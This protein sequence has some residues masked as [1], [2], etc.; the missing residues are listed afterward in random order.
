[1]EEHVNKGFGMLFASRA[2][3]ESFL[4]DQCHPAPLGNIS[5]A[6]PDG[7]VKHR[8]IQDL[9]W[10]KVNR[11]SRVPERGVLPRPLDHGS[12][13]AKVAAQAGEGDVM[14]TLILDFENAFM[15][16]PLAVGEHRY[17]CCEVPQGLRRSRTQ[18]YDSEPEAGQ[19]V[20]WRVL[21]FGG[22]PNPL[23]FARAA[24]VAMRSA[25]CL[26]E[27]LC[28]KVVDFKFQLYVDDPAITVCGP[29]EVVAA[30]IDSVLVWWLVLGLP[31][32]WKKGKLYK[33]HEEHVWVGV[34]Y[35]VLNEGL[36]SMEIPVEYLRDL[37]VMLRP[38]A[39]GVGHF[40]LGDARK[41]VGKA[42]RLA[43]IV[44]EARPFT[45]ALWGG[46]FPEH[47]KLTNLERRK[48]PP[49][50]QPDGDSPW[51]LSGCCSSSGP[52]TRSFRSGGWCRIGRVQWPRRTTSSSNS[53]LARGGRVLHS[54][55]VAD[56]RYIGCTNGRHL[57]SHI[58][59]LQ[60][61]CLIT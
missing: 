10:N 43:Q 5:K 27:A 37:A 60:Q 44:P 29:T 1:M 57:K 14:V 59:R 22:R 25:Q 49:T 48:H 8:L 24:S 26:G 2:E 41:V 21:G 19:F 20:V 4:G 17:N 50:R 54:S 45:G 58:Y 36:V 31:L 13:L 9:K 61:G 46:H 42:G 56:S 51:R 47:G 28:V 30:S 15:S 53:T 35:K 3:A 7:G 40:P 38:L 39:Q 34:L 18:V 6:K 33:I 23:L 11:A 32:A 16:V 52:T 12:D 55:S